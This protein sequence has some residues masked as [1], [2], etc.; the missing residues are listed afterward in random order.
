LVVEVDYTADILKMDTVLVRLRSMLKEF[1][2]TMA[3]DIEL[4][5]Y[6]AL[7]RVPSYVIRPNDQEIL[8]MWKSVGNAI[9]SQMQGY[10][11]AS[12]DL[13]RRGINAQQYCPVTV[14]VNAL[15]ASKEK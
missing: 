15:D 14:V 11:W 3:I 5:D 2:E 7:S 8:Q 10:L 4:L 6:R 12:V 9:A 13:V 1:P